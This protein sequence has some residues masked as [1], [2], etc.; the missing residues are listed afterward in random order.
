MKIALLGATQGMG[1]ALARRFAA[2]GDELFLLGRNA[3][4]L[5]ACAQDLGARTGKSA[6]GFGYA[7]CDLEVPDDF[8]TVLDAAVNRMQ[9]L[10]TV[11]VTAA[12]FAT[13]DRL[14]SDPA[15]RRRLLDVDFARTIEFCEAARERLLA[16]GGGTLCVFGSVA[17]ERGRK[18]VV[19]YGAAKAGLAA[20]LEGLD[21]RFHSRGLHVI[22]VKPGFVRTGMTAGLAEPPFAG[23]A[24]AVAAQV[25]RAIDR[26]TPV[27]YAPPIWAM[28]MFVIR[29]LP[30]ALMRRLGF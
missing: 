8:G 12:L 23:D 28:V 10:D 9:G 15:F 13:Q 24:D 27:V 17:G 26:G 29:L 20:Y 1:R 22:T 14:E 7:T 18:P 5:Q 30:R 2:R 16:R 25:V 4:D 6:T 3:A 21:H 11:V 19:L